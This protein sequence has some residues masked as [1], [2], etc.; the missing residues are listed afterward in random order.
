MGVAREKP[1]SGALDI[2]TFVRRQRGYVAAVSIHLI[3][4]YVFFLYYAW[5]LRCRRI[6][7][8]L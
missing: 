1:S 7:C 2:V 8:F 4:N 3:A 6:N 5:N